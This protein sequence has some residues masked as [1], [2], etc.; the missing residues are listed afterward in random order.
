[1]QTAP[2]S[3][4]SVVAGKVIVMSPAGLTVIRLIDMP[5]TQR[6]QAARYSGQ[7]KCA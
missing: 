1:M 2:L 3:V 6:S 5:E 4:P 7:T